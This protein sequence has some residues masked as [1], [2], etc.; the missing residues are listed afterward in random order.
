M[1]IFTTEIGEDQVSVFLLSSLHNVMLTETG[2]AGSALENYVTGW[3]W[4]WWW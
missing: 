4:R 3:G 2:L 1:T